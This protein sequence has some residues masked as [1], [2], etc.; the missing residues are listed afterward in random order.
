MSDLPA[1]ESAL[2]A[3]LDAN[4]IKFPPYPA[5]AT[6][7][8]QLSRQ[9][10]ST[11]NELATVVSSDPTLAAAVLGRAHSAAHAAN[12]TGRI[13][14]LNEAL[15]RI[16]MQQ[17]IEMALATGLG[18]GAV[19]NGPL[20][21]LRR[22]NWRRALLAAHLARMLAGTRRVAADIAYLAGLLYELGAV[23][24][25]TGL[26]ELAKTKPLPTLPEPEWRRSSAGSRAGSGA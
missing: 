8:E 15:G 16:G 5:V 9:P 3:R 4:Q 10:R 11:L 7:L 2:L 22:D 1:L 13:P 19:A 17:L 26:E 18:N 12:G 21:E 24:A 14:T 6:K 23:V 20:A 25:T